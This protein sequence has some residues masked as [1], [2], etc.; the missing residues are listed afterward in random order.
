MS[1]NINLR[2]ITPLVAEEKTVGI[3]RS[4]QRYE[5]EDASKNPPPNPNSTLNPKLFTRQTLDLSEFA[6]N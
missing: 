3:K 5:D 2:V 1:K 4:S 6:R